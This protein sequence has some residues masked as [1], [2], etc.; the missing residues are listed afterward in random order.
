MTEEAHKQAVKDQFT[1][2]AEEY[3]QWATVDAG[4]AKSDVAFFQPSPEDCALDVACGPGTLSLKLAALTRE[5]VGIDLTDELLAIARR[6][7]GEQ[8]LQNVRFSSADVENIPFP[9]ESFD[10]VVCGSAL[11]HFPDP[12]RVFREM[13]R[14]CRAGG[15]LGVIDIVSPEEEARAARALEIRRLRDPS[16]A[17][18]LKPSEILQLFEALGLHS[19]RQKTETRAE[20]F[21]P[22]AKTGGLTEGEPR[23]EKIK[24]LLES[25]IEGDRTGWKVRRVGDD[26]EFDRGYFYACGTKR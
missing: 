10:L 13:H 21:R 14:V 20:R 16:H 25:S 7:A 19:L 18:A 6:K 1:K 11:H 26:L 2:T 9:A 12:E 4:S 15:R 5:V 3:A 8:H 17:R 24:K 22:W 23:Y